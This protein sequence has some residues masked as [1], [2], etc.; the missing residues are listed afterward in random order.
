[1]GRAHFL[2]DA[3]AFLPASAL[4]GK[5][6]ALGKAINQLA[7]HLIELQFQ[8]PDLIRLVDRHALSIIAIREPGGCVRQALDTPDR[9]AGCQDPKKQA[10]ARSQSGP[11]FQ[12]LIL[13]RT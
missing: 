5:C 7:S 6:L 11:P 3:G 9:A 2:F 12:P 4:L 1:M 8:L 10:H 13:P